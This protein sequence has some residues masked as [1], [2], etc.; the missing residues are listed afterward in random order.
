MFGAGE[1]L[2]PPDAYLEKPLDPEML[3]RTIRKLLP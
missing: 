2:P 3:L 1:A